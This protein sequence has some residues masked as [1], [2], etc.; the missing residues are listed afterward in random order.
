MPRE[1]G[2]SRKSAEIDKVP[3]E[4]PSTLDT[5]F[6]LAVIIG[7]A[8]LLHSSQ[9]PALLLDPTLLWSRPYLVGVASGLTFIVCIL[10]LIIWR[11]ILQRGATFRHWRVRM[12]R[13]IQV[14]TLSGIISASSLTI[15]FWP[16]YGFWTIPLFSVL[17]YVVLCL[18]SF[19]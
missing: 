2:S 14:L 3:G 15:A 10:L 9:I 19:V 13:P 18:L 8:I 11:H 7:G 16:V 17:S 4:G 5:I 12:R 6:R 1:K